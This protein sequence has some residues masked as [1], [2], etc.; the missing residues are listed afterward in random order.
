MSRITSLVLSGGGTVG[1][2]MFGILQESH[3]KQWWNLQEIKKIYAT[4]VGSILATMIS[5]NYDWEILD[6]YLVKRPWQHVFHVSM[7]TIFGCINNRGFFSVCIMEEIFSSLFKGKDL[8]PD[9]SMLEFVERLGIELFFYTSEINMLQESQESSTCISAKTHPNWRV[10]DAVYA[11]CCLPLLFSPHITLNGECFVDGGITNNYPLLNCLLENSPENVFGIYA[12]VNF[13]A[14]SRIGAESS[15]VDYLVF[16]VYQIFGTLFNK[17]IQKP[18][19]AREI[20]IE[21]SPA[22]TLGEIYSCIYSADMRRELIQRGVDL[23]LN[24]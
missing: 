12:D 18:S 19:I 6:D 8:S 2:P 4:S 17:P 20:F 3:K 21:I 5:L 23:C 13:V 16:L 15:L 1:F 14:L 9:I 24:V 7:E 10:V 11:S 22:K